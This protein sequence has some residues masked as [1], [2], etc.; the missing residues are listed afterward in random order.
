MVR[1]CLHIP[2]ENLQDVHDHGIQ[3]VLVLGTKRV[4]SVQHDQLDVVVCL[5]DDEFGE[6]RGGSLECI[7]DCDRHAYLSVC[8]AHP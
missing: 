6:C 7:S 3:H 5:P 4:E 2:R 1:V 8:F